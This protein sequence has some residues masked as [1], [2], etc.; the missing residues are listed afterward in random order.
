[1]NVNVYTH[2]HRVLILKVKRNVT[3]R[4][5][6]VNS[7][8]QIP[9]RPPSAEPREEKRVQSHHSGGSEGRSRRRALPAPTAVRTQ[10]SHWT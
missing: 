4:N 9:E 3:L 6:A 1:M 8:S 7:P 2:T 10:T 5:Y